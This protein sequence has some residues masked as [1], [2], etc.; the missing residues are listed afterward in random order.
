MRLIILA[1]LMFIS[2][3][4]LAQMPAGM[5]EAINCMQSLDQEALKDM[6]E[7]GEKVG[8]EIKALCEDGDESGARE[9]A[10]EYI[11]DIEDNEVIEELKTCSELMRKAMP[12]MPIPE[13][14]NA[15]MYEEEADSICENLD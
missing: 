8:N 4:A 3:F 15:D 14:P 5:Q 11:K 13:I 9:V 6:G 7:K 12:N 2:S 1:S 10:M